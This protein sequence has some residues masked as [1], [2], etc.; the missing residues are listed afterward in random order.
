MT[1]TEDHPVNDES[2]RLKDHITKNAQF[3]IKR[4]NKN[5]LHT[6]NKTVSIK[7]ENQTIQ[8]KRSQKNKANN[9]TTMTPR[10]NNCN[11]K[12]AKN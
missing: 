9:A 2:R 11:N 3:K 12:D 5:M 8:S 6:R 1:K 10:S 4:G 7:Q